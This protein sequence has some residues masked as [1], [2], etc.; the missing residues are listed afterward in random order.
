V[1]ARR[2]ALAAC[3][4]NGVHAAT[5]VDPRWHRSACVQTD[6][7]TQR[8]PTARQSRRGHDIKLRDEHGT[9]SIPIARHRLR[10]RF[11]PTGS[12]A[13]PTRTSAAPMIGVRA[14]RR[15]GKRLSAL[16]RSRHRRHCFATHLL[17]RGQDIR[18]VQALLGHADVSTTMI[19]THVLKVGGGGVRSPL[20]TA[21]A[22]APTSTLPFAWQG[23]KEPAGRYVVVPQSAPTSVARAART[24]AAT[25]LRHSIL[26][27][28]T[29]TR[30]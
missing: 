10:G 20:D 15:P 26:T 19:Y 8:L 14:P 22:T 17:Q 1:A 25:S 5:M 21:A 27:P 29:A 18:T 23:V 13:Y 30:P 11:S 3:A 4:N 2:P 24:A 6:P 12:F 16:C 28:A 9:D 7:Q